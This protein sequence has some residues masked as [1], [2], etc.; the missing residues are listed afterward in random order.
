MHFTLATV[1]A[2]ASAPI[3]MA[4]MGSGTLGPVPTPAVPTPAVPTPAVPTPTYP[5]TQILPV[6]GWNSTTD[7]FNTL[8]AL[9]AKSATELSAQVFNIAQKNIALSGSGTIAY[10]YDIQADLA[11]ALATVNNL[12]WSTA[13][14]GEERVCAIVRSINE[15]NVG[16]VRGNLL[17]AIT[18]EAQ[19]VIRIAITLGNTVAAV[20][21]QIRE[22]TN[23]EKTVLATLIRAIA[24]AAVAS[25]GPLAK[26][27]AGLTA[28]GN[29]ALNEA[30]DSLQVAVAG[31]QA[32]AT[33]NWTFE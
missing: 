16:T 14:E 7:S 27:N 26:L 8:A 13:Y 32:A 30:I 3:A 6:P 24:T 18:A 10:S 9:Y 19:A 17:I 11:A 29:T 20:Q 22:F 12:F 28:T 25:T 2:L 5:T 33:I 15:Q 23:A 21:S 4:Q 1:L 31:L